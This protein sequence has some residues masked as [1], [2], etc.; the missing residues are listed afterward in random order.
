VSRTRRGAGEPAVGPVLDDVAAGARDTA[1]PVDARDTESE[2]DD[3]LDRLARLGEAPAAPVVDEPVALPLIVEADPTYPPVAAVTVP[4][5]HR[6]PPA[7]LVVGAGIP[8]SLD[9]STPVDTPVADVVTAAAPDVVPDV[10]PGSAVSADLP[11]SA[12][13]LAASPAVEAVEA[14]EASALALPLDRTD[15]APLV[16]PDV[17]PQFVPAPGPVPMAPSG[18]VAVDESTGM[19]LPV[20]RLR[21]P[22]VFRRAKPRVRRVTRVVRH[23]DT[24]SVFKV[25]L[26]FNVI[27]YLVCLTAG[28]LLWNVAHATGTIDNVERFFEQFG[29]E[30]FEFQGGEIY[31]NAWIGGLFV[32]IG[33]TGFAVLLA[34]LFNLITDLVGGIRVSVL[35]EEVIATPRRAGDPT[36]STAST[37]I[38]RP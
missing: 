31:H 37:G 11:T 32:V 14:V 28:V 4:D 19:T 25:A 6:D 18:G 10:V 27:L 16:V 23:V 26:V 35:E 12:V 38:P 8:A 34:T 30:T 24:W 1:D 17:V 33:L 15:V 36:G 2:V 9:A 22:L 29:W 20:R 5:V 21:A 7:D 3:V 13:G